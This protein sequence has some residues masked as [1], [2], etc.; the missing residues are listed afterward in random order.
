M[1]ASYRSQDLKES[2]GLCDSIATNV[3]VSCRR[4]ACDGDFVQE[5][6]FCKD[7]HLDWKASRLDAITQT[8]YRTAASAIKLSTFGLTLSLFVAPFSVPVSLGLMAATGVVLVA[9]VAFEAASRIRNKVIASFRTESSMK[10]EFVANAQTKLL[11]S[12][13]D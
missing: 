12:G 7:C 3:C 5:T 4:P 8:E 6:D 11:D 2:C 10:D 9:G 1:A 13:D